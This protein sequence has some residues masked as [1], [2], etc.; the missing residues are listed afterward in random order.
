LYSNNIAQDKNTRLSDVIQLTIDNYGLAKSSSSRYISYSIENY[1]LEYDYNFN[2]SMRKNSE[3]Q[4]A[5][6]K[7]AHRMLR[8]LSRFLEEAGDILKNKAY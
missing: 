3:N 1:K 4:E 5:S 6:K 2:G 7:F 8:E